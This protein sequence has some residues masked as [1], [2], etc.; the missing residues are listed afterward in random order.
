MPIIE[1]TREQYD[2][3]KDEVESLTV[4][5]SEIVERLKQAREHGKFMLNPEF[6][7][8]QK[9]LA[10]VKSKI[11]DIESRLKN[12]IIVER[13]DEDPG[14]FLNHVQI[15]SLVRVRY[16]ETG[17]EEE[18]TVTSDAGKFAGEGMLSA[19][20]PVAKALMR[21]CKGSKCNVKCRDGTTYELEILSVKNPV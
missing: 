11:C 14:Q 19:E 17:E 21:R 5:R 6:D 20:T 13:I 12:A 3:L 8:A 10:D 15:G 1:M 18:F 2:A 7:A 16:T 9:E 4:K